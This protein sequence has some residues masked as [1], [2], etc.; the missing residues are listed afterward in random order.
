LFD[1]RPDRERNTG[2]HFILHRKQIS[3]V[4][5]VVL[6]PEMHTSAGFNELRRHPHSISRLAHAAFE[7]IPNTE[8]A[9]DIF[10][11]D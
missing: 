8:L 2:G 11:P 5:V 1:R 4:A 3:E 10:D 7:D 9:P 6:A